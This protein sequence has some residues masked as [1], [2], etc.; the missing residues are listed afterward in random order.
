MTD[1]GRNLRVTFDNGCIFDLSAELLRVHS[2]SAEVQGHSA[3]GRKCVGGKLHVAI[4]DILPVGHYAVRLVFS[5][6]H[7]SGLFTWGFLHDIGH[8]AAQKWTA[9]LIEL[10]AKGLS[11]ERPGE[12]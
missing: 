6:G 7:D 2:P 10:E 1:K 3:A 8:H 12:K 4:A 11:R 5:D 9:Y